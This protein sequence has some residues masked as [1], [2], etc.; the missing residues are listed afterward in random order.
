MIFLGYDNNSK[1]FRCYNITP[2]RVVISRDV[3]FTGSIQNPDHTEVSLEEENSKSLK[4]DNEKA[5][6]NDIVGAEV[7]LEFQAD[8]PK[9]KSLEG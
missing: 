7:K 9:V 1:A 4:T 3:R 2:N 6:N 8:R 5:I